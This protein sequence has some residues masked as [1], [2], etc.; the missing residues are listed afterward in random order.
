MSLNPSSA[1]TSDST[2]ASESPY[3]KLSFNINAFKGNTA[4][5]NCCTAPKPKAMTTNVPVQPLDGP[6]PSFGSTVRYP[7]TIMP[8]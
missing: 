2:I 5:F 3:A 4:S 8:M 1:S 7:G 6:M